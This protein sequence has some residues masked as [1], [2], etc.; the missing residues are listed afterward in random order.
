MF[1]KCDLLILMFRLTGTCSDFVA[2]HDAVDLGDTKHYKIKSLAI[3]P[4]DFLIINVGPSLPSCF[5]LPDL[6]YCVIILHDF[7]PN[8]YAYNP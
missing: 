5:F 6:S 4:T 7:I 1:F 2:F 8:Y 3:G